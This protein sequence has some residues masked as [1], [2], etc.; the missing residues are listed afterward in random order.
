[1]SSLC[2]WHRLPFRYIQPP[3]RL[4]TSIQGTAMNMIKAREK[5][6]AFT[7]K[8]SRCIYL[9]WS[10]NYANFLQ[11][12]INYYLISDKGYEKIWRKLRGYKWVERLRTTALQRIRTT[13]SLTW[14]ETKIIQQSMGNDSIILRFVRCP[15]VVAR[16]VC[17]PC[18][19][20]NYS[21]VNWTQHKH[22]WRT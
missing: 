4:N 2:L 5:I 22:D 3:Q 10:G 19:N 15:G 14:I 13:S 6:T 12:S 16:I 20:P 8:L 18:C 7:N 17:F 21:A 1:M 11:L 9:M